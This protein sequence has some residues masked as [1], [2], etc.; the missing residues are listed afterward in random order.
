MRMTI[1]LIALLLMVSQTIAAEDIPAAKQYQALLDEYEQEG[2]ARIFAKR[3]LKLAQQHRQHP[4]GAAALLWVVKNVRGKPDTTRALDLLAK[5]HINSELL[6]P[7]CETIAGSRSIAAEKLL[8]AASENNPHLQVRAQAYYY[9]AA[10]LDLEASLVEQLRAQPELASRVLQYYG[11]EYGTHL[12][13]LEPGSLAQQRELVY[14][15]I[16]ESF[17]NVQMQDGRMGEIAEKML[18]QIRHLS[19]GK[20]APEISGEDIHGRNFKL[21]DYRGKVVMLT[22]WGH[23]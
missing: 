12:S 23:W 3:F 9:L 20:V 15:R 14:Q 7:A 21:G 10:L 8:R 6:G 11:K 13:S 17:P 2:G 1:S 5:H 19:I 18:F 16:L 22:F 4:A